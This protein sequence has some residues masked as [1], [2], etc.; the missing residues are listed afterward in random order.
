MM[1]PVNLEVLDVY[2]GKVAFGKIKFSSIELDENYIS[3]IETLEFRLRMYD[4]ETSVTI[5][6]TDVISL[7]FP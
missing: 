6:E 7:T 5:C 1:S 3:T 4:A 2:P